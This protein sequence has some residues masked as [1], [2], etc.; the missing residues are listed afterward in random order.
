MIENTSSNLINGDYIDHV[1][2]TTNATYADSD[3]SRSGE[4]EAVVDE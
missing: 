4:H 3:S 2:T 1:D